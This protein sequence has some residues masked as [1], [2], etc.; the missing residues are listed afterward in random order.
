MH[1]Q[2]QVQHVRILHITDTHLSGTHPVFQFNWHLFAARVRALQPDL[3]IHTGDAAIS[4]PDRVEDIAFARAEMDKLGVR[5]LIVP[6]NHDVGDN[7]VTAD[8]LHRQP[9][10]CTEERRQ[11]WIT[12]FGPDFWV[13]EIDGYRFVGL[14]AQLFGT[15]LVAE[16]AQWDMLREALKAG[17]QIVLVSHKPLYS[18]VDGSDLPLN[19]IPPDASRE[20]EALCTE[21]GVL[22]HLSG[23]LHRHKIIERAGFPRVWGASTAFVCSHEKMSRRNGRI[24]VGMQSVTLGTAAPEI[25]FVPVLE[26]INMDIRNWLDPDS[27]GLGAVLAAASPI[28]IAPEPEAETAS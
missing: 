20:I 14:N 23:H 17:G 7:P 24:E 4:D 18:Q 8:W 12:H 21:T 26:A 3:V 2:Q 6:G 5:Y 9:K 27:A 19:S 22:V 28:A 11:A 1:S 16:D 15:G 25:A 10:H 13:E